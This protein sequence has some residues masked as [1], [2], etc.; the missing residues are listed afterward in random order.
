MTTQHTEYEHNEEHDAQS[1][2][3]TLVD[4][5][6][7][8][9]TS[10]PDDTPS[11]SDD[12]ASETDVSHNDTSS[13]YNDASATEHSSSNEEDAP[14]ATTAFAEETG[15]TIPELSTFVHVEDLQLPVTQEETSTPSAQGEVFTGSTGDTHIPAQQETAPTTTTEDVQAPVAQ[16]DTVSAS[17]AVADVQVPI[18]QGVTS[19]EKAEPVEESLAS[20]AQSE[21]IAP[22][23][24]DAVAAPVFVTESETVVAEIAPAAEASEEHVRPFTAFIEEFQQAQAQAEAQAEA[25]LTASLQPSQA[26]GFAEFAT[27]ERT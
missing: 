2:D 17:D 4:Q 25:H 8:S 7:T 23:T 3:E 13:T 12:G 16:E 14:I 24:V 19:S 1:V 15:N 9:D 27:P 26:E 5:Q 18:Q 10:M 11:S 20:V 22:E 6:H 21:Q